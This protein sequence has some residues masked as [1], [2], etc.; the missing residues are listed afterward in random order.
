MNLQF[1][2]CRITGPGAGALATTAV[3]GSDAG[4][5]IDR[6]FIPLG[7]SRPSQADCRSILFGTIVDPDNV[8]NESP[9]TNT[10]SGEQVVV[11]P[12][13]ASDSIRVYEIH[14]HGGKAAIDSTAAILTRLGGLPASVNQ[15]YEQT[16]RFYSSSKTKN[17]KY[18]IPSASAELQELAAYKIDKARLFDRL[19]KAPTYKTAAILLDQ[20]NG[21]FELT[22]QKIAQLQQSGDD[23]SARAVIGQL[24]NTRNIGRHLIQ[25][26]KIVIVGKPNAGKSSLLNCLLGFQ[27]AIVNPLCGTTRDLVTAQTVFDGWPIELIDS[28]GLRQSDDVLEQEG[29]RRAI[30]AIQ[31]ADLIL[32]T[33]DISEFRDINIDIHRYMRAISY[34]NAVPDSI[35]IITV[36]N[37]AD[38]TPSAS[39]RLDSDSAI[40]VSAKT[41]WQIETLIEKIVRTLIPQPPKP[42]EAVIVQ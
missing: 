2:F 34:L 23:S 35:P 13:D 32:L 42:G 38:L 19:Q 39:V 17:K 36:L 26:W 16:N 14:G 20:Y 15:W 37:K 41:G 28:A 40:S 11:A 5:A 33:A 6:C 3:W 22:L 7:K 10:L 12:I 1:Q 27:R 31:T 24:K 4:K 18:T 29:V 25:P 8:S 30:A 9:Q 21:A